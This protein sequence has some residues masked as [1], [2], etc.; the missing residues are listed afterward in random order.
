MNWRK[1]FRAPPQE[2]RGFLRFSRENW[3][4]RSKGRSAQRQARLQ[5]QSSSREKLT[6]EF[7]EFLREAWASPRVFMLEENV[8]FFPRLILRELYKLRQIVFGILD[9][10]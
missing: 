10:T 4:Y 6:E 2:A 7:F 8:N 9:A 1:R 5:P 3:N